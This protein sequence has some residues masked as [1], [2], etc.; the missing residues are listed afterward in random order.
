[1]KFA[2]IGHLLDSQTITNLPQEWIGKKYIISPEIDI[3]GVK[4]RFFLLKI[5][6]EQIMKF[7]REKVRNDILNCVLY[8]QREY[9]IDLIQLGA[10][11]TSVTQGGKWILNQRDYEGYINHG[12]SFTAAIAEQT[13]FKSLEFFNLD[14][15]N[16][17]ISIVGAYGIIGEALSKLITPRFRK[18]ILI[19]RQEEKLLELKEKITQ[20]VSISTELKTNTSDVIITATNH[21]TALLTSEHIKRNAIIIDVSQPSNVSKELCSSRLDIRRIDGG[22]V[23]FPSDFNIPTLPNGKILS[24]VAEIIMQALENDKKNY[25]G[26]I[27]LNHLNK[28]IQWGKKYGFTLNELTNFGQSIC[29]INRILD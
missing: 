10:L 11:T 28:T 22:L 27:N 12:D 6:A 26:S 5:T 3:Q 23:H 16:L 20:D 15:K 13:V 1:M 18:C 14:S 8:A 4:G 17:T 19:G 7:D 25:V 21:P 29:T 2:S 24:C 9:D